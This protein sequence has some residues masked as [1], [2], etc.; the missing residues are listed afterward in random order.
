MRGVEPNYNK[1][2][3]MPKVAK[4]EKVYKGINKVSPKKEAQK[5]Q[6]KQEDIELSKFCQEWYDRHPTK[7]CFECDNKIFNYKPHNG[8]HIIGKKYADKYNIDIVCS[9]ENL[10]LLCLTD[11]SKAETNIDHAPKVKELTEKT[12]KAFE[13]YLIK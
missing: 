1:F 6:K 10:V 8:H 5:E 2:N 9:E 12:Y 3:P 11:H 13:K 7:R 4:V